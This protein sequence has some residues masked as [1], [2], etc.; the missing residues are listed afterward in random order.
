M[1][2]VKSSRLSLLYL[3]QVSVQSMECS[4]ERNPKS[5]ELWNMNLLSTL[6]DCYRKTDERSWIG[7][8][9]TIPF[10]CCWLTLFLRLVS[11]LRAC[12]LWHSSSNSSSG[13]S[14]LPKLKN[15]LLYLCVAH[16]HTT[17]SYIH[18]PLYKNV[19][20]P[21]VPIRKFKGRRGKEKF[22]NDSAIHTAV[23]DAG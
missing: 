2:L 21:W 20:W 15:L 6:V 10:F 18:A 17:R 8:A 1:Y 4:H 19:S 22:D 14:K 11:L 13:S 3:F 12:M 7:T 23:M 16:I 5:R 9:T